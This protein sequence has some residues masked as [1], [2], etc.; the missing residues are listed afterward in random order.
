MLVETNLR[1]APITELAGLAARAEALGFDGIAQSELRGD[2]FL[3]VGLMATSTSRVRLATSVAIAFPRS[4]TVVAYLAR[5]LQALSSNRFALG[6]GTQVRAHVERRFATAWGAGGPRLRDYLFALRA[7]FDCWNRGTPLNY[8]GKYEQLS[9]MTPEFSPGPSRFGPIPLQIAAVNPYNLQLAG[10]L[11]DGLRVHSFTTPAYIR[12]VILPN[13]E[14]GA[15]RAGRSLDQVEVIGGGSIATGPDEATVAVKR[16]EAR[17]R[18]AFYGST[19]AYRPVFEHHGWPDLSPALAR[20]VAQGRWNDLPSL[21]PDDVLDT[22]CTSGTYDT[23]ATEITQRIGGL[24]DWI[25][26]ACPDEADRADD[27][28][29][30]ALADLRAVPGRGAK[31]G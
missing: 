10:E 7:L 6:L 19:R 2:A 29:R 24:V 31:A 8:Q 18:I 5:D 1:N 21:I 23:I 28:L 12:D 13:L 15:T 20:L 25:N 4:P 26:I 9:L 11:C 17:R 22:F 30:Q 3:A 27:R 14:K 16:E